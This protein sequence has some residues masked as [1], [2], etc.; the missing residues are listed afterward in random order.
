MRL[1]C[2]LACGPFGLLHV[3]P[4][5]RRGRAQTQIC[6]H[7]ARRPMSPL[8]E[9]TRLLARMGEAF[10]KAVLW[11]P[12]AAWLDYINVTGWQSL[13]LQTVPGNGACLRHCPSE[14]QCLRAG[15][16][17][18]LSP[19]GARSFRMNVLRRVPLRRSSQPCTFAIESDH[20]CA[21]DEPLLSQ[22]ADRRCLQ[23]GGCLVAVNTSLVTAHVSNKKQLLVR[24]IVWSCFFDVVPRA[25][26]VPCSSGSVV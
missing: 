9:A 10:L 7:D 12:E 23:G 20:H 13:R 5:T 8:P 3:L 2:H 4:C 6:Y 17:G 22:G 18:R 21:I 1:V 11:K 26:V 19:K 14:G 16:L 25:F 15:A 24:V